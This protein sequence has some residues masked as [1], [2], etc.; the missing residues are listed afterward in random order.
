M[1]NVGRYWLIGAVLGVAALVTACTPPPT[2]APDPLIECEQ[3]AGSIDYDPP[4][5]NSGEDITLT[6][7]PAAALSD[8]TDH[9]GAGIT[10]GSLD[11]SV[12]LPGYLCDEL[13]IGAS[14]GAGTGSIAW[15]D[16]S[17][18]T[19]DV[20]ILG[21]PSSFI[22]ELTI[23]GG[24]W[25]RASGQTAV[26]VT[27]SVGYCDPAWG[28]V[29]RAELSSDDPIA[30]HAPI[31]PTLPPRTDLAQVE[32]GSGNTTC[33]VMEN[34]TVTCWGD[35]SDGQLGNVL[36]A[37]GSRSTLPIPVTGLTGATQVGVGVNHNCA[38]VGTG[39]RCWGR[40]DVGQLG[41]GTTNSSN[42]P[43]QVLGLGGG[44]P[45]RQISVGYPRTC[46]LLV[47]GTVRCWGAG[48]G[49]G[50]TN[51][52]TP[53]AVGGL[54]GVTQ[55]AAGSGHTCALLGDGTVRC[56]G[57]NANGQLGNGTTTDSLLPVDVVGLA[58][59]TQI[60]AGSDHTCALDAVGDVRCWGMN[61]F[62]QLGR[63]SSSSDPATT[64]DL[65]L[66]NLEATSIDAGGVVTC[67]LVAGGAVSCWGGNEQGSLGNGITRDSARPTL[68]LGMTGATSASAG[69]HSCAT[70]PGGR[71]ACWGSNWSGE[72]GDGTLR[73]RSVAS[74]V[75]DP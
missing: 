11:L 71:A 33:A 35:N 42:V 67:A 72:L 36:Y 29:T 13:D 21:G 58:G 2:P 49:T 61:Y 45:V 25:N 22:V 23:S 15:S 5:M 30:F 26:F 53:V 38:L 75:L 68:V 57:T 48:A 34:G 56:W 69:G 19:V 70:L 66:R 17:A 54:T 47:D 73:P 3:L 55:I 63:G 51:D 24:R 37:P 1:S 59:V 7:R 4:A 12:V 43:V 52:P 64:P 18:S 39:V 31:A 9:T 16:G 62:G 32:S 8:C 10:S 46:A 20:E 60:T 44:T 74:P 27:S 28:G 41:N 40:N 50:G 65:V 14:I 6:T